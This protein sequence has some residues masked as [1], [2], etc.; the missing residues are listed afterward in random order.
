MNLRDFDYA[1]PP[2]LIAQEPAALRDRSRLM[3]L[4]RKSGRVSH[5]RFVNLPEFIRPGDTLV[6]N[7]T[8]VRPV[9]LP[10]TK[11]TGGKVE[12]LLVRKKKGEA[13]EESGEWDCL[14]KNAGRLRPPAVL[15]FHEEVRG[16]VLGRTADGLWTLRLRGKSGLEEALD[17]IGYPPLPPYIRRRGREDLREKDLER[18]QTIYAQKP[19]AIAAPTAGLHFSP[20]VLEKI[21]LRKAR[22]A[23]LT[24]HVGIGTFL[25]VKTERVENHRLEAETFELPAE[26]AAAIEAAR[27]AGGRVMA[28]GTTVVRT[29]EHLSDE[30]GRV[31][32]ANGKTGL[33]ILPG[34]RFKAVD[35]LVTN[36]H[37]PRST[38]LMLVSAFAGREKILA[39][40]EEAVKERYRF[41]SYGDSML[42]Q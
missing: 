14:I 19:G 10:G 12:V 6:L 35:A 21:R 37:L 42:I 26:S 11:E 5:D 33:F 25:P 27:G 28:V 40:Y 38:L 39:A 17:R 32:P 13:D 4:D 24:L 1:L 23:F 29:L 22:V 15:F 41:Y 30:T 18:Y 9:R 31:N 16:E 34:Y 3:I 36:F 2:E 20:E 8:R 7:D